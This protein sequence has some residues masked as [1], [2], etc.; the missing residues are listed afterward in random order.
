M[1]LGCTRNPLQ[2]KVFP[3]ERRVDGKSSVG[4]SGFTSRGIVWRL[5]FSLLLLLA[6]V[7]LSIAFWQLLRVNFSLPFWPDVK[8]QIQLKKQRRAGGDDQIVQLQWGKLV[9]CHRR[10]RRVNVRCGVF[11]RTLYL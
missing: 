4:S 3:R 5:K 10:S 9:P 11:T 2:P 7:Q 6:L 1:A 8:K